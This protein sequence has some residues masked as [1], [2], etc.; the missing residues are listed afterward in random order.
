MTVGEIVNSIISLDKLFDPEGPMWVPAADAENG[1]DGETAI[2]SASDGVDGIVVV[3]PSST[4][5]AQKNHSVVTQPP[6]HPVVSSDGIPMQHS[7]TNFR[8]KF[9][10]SGRRKSHAANVV[11]TSTPKSAG[12]PSARI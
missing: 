12:Q 8:H 11:V 3:A 9:S 10:Q 7:R 2:E 5:A 1:A 6:T 4:G